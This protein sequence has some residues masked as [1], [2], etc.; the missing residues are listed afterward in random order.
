MTETPQEMLSRLTL[1]ASGERECDMSDNDIAALRWL[2]GSGNPA[3]QE[4]AVTTGRSAAQKEPT[5]DLGP[6]SARERVIAAG[7]LAYMQTPAGTIDVGIISEFAAR[8][9]LIIAK[10]RNERYAPANPVDMNDEYRRGQCR[11]Y[12]DAARHVE[13]V[14]AELTKETDDATTDGA[15]GSTNV[16]GGN[17]GA[18]VSAGAVALPPDIEGLLKEAAERVSCGR[19]AFGFDEPA[20][21]ACE[22]P[23]DWH[24]IGALAAALRAEA[25]AHQQAKEFAAYWERECQSAQREVVAQIEVGDKMLANVNAALEQAEQALDA[26]IEKA[27]KAGWEYRSQNARF[28]GSQAAD[29]F[30][31][32]LKEQP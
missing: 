9:G 8:E 11:G 30:A 21:A 19:E 6:G 12:A 18:G 31:A 29:A 24:L 5:R 4:H 13:M 3:T 26:A 32:Y 25:T 20:C 28:G 22:A 17:R 7:M 27:F 10:E 16:L 15:K 23:G 14:L 2:L 1:I